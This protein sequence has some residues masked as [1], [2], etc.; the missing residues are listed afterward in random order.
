MAT[1]AASEFRARHSS[2]PGR[3]LAPVKSGLALP[4]LGGAHS[5]SKGAQGQLLVIF[6]AMGGLGMLAWELHEARA[7]QARLRD[8]VANAATLARA[9]LTDHAHT[10][11]RL[12]EATVE[13]RMLQQLLSD[14]GQTTQDLRR[15]LG[16]TEAS[17]D[18]ALRNGAQQ[19]Q[20]WS[21]Q[22]TELKT[23]LDTESTKRGEA[24]QLAAEREAESQQLAAESA[25]LQSR[26]ASMQQE[27]EALACELGRLH[28]SLHAAQGENASLRSCNE[29]LHSEVSSLRSCNEQLRS[30][31]SSQQS[32]I[33]TLQSRISCLEGE[34]SRL[35][36]QRD[37]EGKQ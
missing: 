27:G 31:V 17:R 32:T 8:A 5:L 24:E 9:S 18:E 22:N 20:A 34:V 19:V 37:R 12:A 14:A 33:S 23:T 7:E 28:A 36:C 11:H 25:D 4:E 15:S 16:D 1:I 3:R 6:L 13:R 21:I 35:G 29:Q 26:V 10:K 2:A 30:E